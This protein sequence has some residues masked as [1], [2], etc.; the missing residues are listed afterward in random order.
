M[1]LEHVEVHNGVLQATSTNADPA[2]VSPALE[3]RATRFT[4]LV[5]AMRS[6][7]PSGP[8]QLFW[9][10]VTEPATSEAAGVSAATVADGRWHRYALPVATNPHWGGCVTSLRF[11]PATVKGAAIEIKSIRLE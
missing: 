11:D 9:T 10:T 4:K 2:F 5:V 6:R 3:L 7:S 1:G 8:V